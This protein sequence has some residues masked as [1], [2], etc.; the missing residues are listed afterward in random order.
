MMDVASYCG[1]DAV[2][3]Q[4]RDVK[5]YLSLEQYNRI[6]DNPNSFGLTY[7]EHREYLEL[8]LEEHIELKEYASSLGIDYFVSVWDA[9]SVKQML[10]LDIDILKIPSAC[11]TDSKLLSALKDAKV[12]VMASVGMSTI[13]EIDFLVNELSAIEDLYLFQCTSTYPCSFDNL[14]L[15]VIGM[16][17]KRYQDKVKG[18]GF[19]GHHLGIAMD[20]AAV[21]MGAEIIERHFTLDRTQKGTDHAASLEPDGMRR[22]VRDI[23]AFEKAKGTC[24]KK[25]L[26][27]ELS[28]WK[29]LRRTKE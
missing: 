5:S 25:R 20:V 27:C 21:A 13:E 26:D 11:I 4:K 9:E 12:P 29:K 10:D 17:K 7:G 18:I 16:L 22:L 24:E 8:N 23:R 19:S 15:S 1:V 3:L 2:K 14:N 28:A 6:Y